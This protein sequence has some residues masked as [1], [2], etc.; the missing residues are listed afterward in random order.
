MHDIIMD[1]EAEDTVAI[2]AVEALIQ[3]ERFK[4]EMRGIPALKPIELKDAPQR[5]RRAAGPK[6]IRPIQAKG[7]SSESQTVTPPPPVG[8]EKRESD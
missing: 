2:K 7:I 4:R 3:V 8:G 6:T 5:Q 1:Q